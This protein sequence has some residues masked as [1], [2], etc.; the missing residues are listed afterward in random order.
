M[1][2]TKEENKLYRDVQKTQNGRVW[3]IFIVSPLMIIAGVLPKIPPVLKIFLVI[4]G[5]ALIVTAG[6]SFIKTNKEQ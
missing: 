1:N 2:E 5:V 3:S 6:F 4:S